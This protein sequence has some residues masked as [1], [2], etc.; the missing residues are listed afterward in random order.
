MSHEV[1]TALGGIGLF[2]YGM[3]TMTDALRQV[4]G[5]RIRALLARFTRTPLA[6]AVTGTLATAA[7]QSSSATTVTVVGLVG[8]GLLAFPQAVGVILGANV[9]TTLTGWIVVLLGI[10]LKLGLLVLPVLFAGSL[11][12]IAARG[13]PARLGLVM[14]GFSLIFLGLDMLQ[15]GLAGF[16]G[17]ITPQML[18]PDSFAGRLLIILIGAA[19]TAV[20]QSSS[21]GVAATLVLLDGG[22]I[23][24]A[25]GAALVIG[26]DIGTTVTAVL[27]AVGGSRAMR[28]TGLAH[29]FYNVITG[30]VAFLMLG[31]VAPL[32]RDGLAGGDN[33]FGLVL[34]HTL[35]NVIGVVLMLPL[36]TPFARLIERLVPEHPAPLSEALDRRLLT[37][38][39]AALDAAHSTAQAIAL[40]L[41]RGLGEAL[42]PGG[43]I[44]AP[45]HTA[46][47]T[48][49]ALTALQ[50]YLAR[51]P[52]PEDQRELLERYGALL[53]QVD[54]L[55]R[56]QHRT[57]Q[58][59]RLLPLMTHPLLRRPASLLG[60]ILRLAAADGRMPAE[61]RLSRL[62]SV[63]AARTQRLRQAALAS[64][65]GVPADQ[66]FALTDSVRWLERT[67]THLVRINHYLA[68]A[69]D[70]SPAAPS[71]PA[72]SG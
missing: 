52:V 34:F 16:E 11:L 38:P 22:A 67:L 5:A 45:R 29:V 36:T 47:R 53:H 18:P 55:N 50:E 3:A 4:A 41:C 68:V 8:A 20:T 69:A 32:V 48:A 2:L 1:L 49:P 39:G 30:A 7:V 27:A 62:A 58:T 40:A 31:L 56:L 70:G 23:S 61:P 33:D 42:R 37:D 51:I 65:P 24:F 26:M 12:R 28:Q 13:S 64:R 15:A 57:M 14:V 35:F 10:K 17:R 6:G 46:E 59:D 44:E 21:A 54:H 72:G 9:G 43:R 25:Q 63:A 71:E 66:L 19:I 60:G